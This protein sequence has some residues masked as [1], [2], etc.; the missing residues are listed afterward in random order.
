M[1][2]EVI[3]DP[4]GFMDGIQVGDS[5]KDLIPQTEMKKFHAFIRKVG[6]KGFDFAPQINIT[7]DNTSYS[8]SLMGMLQED[9]VYAS[10][11]QVPSYLTFIYEDLMKIINELGRQLRNSQRKSATKTEFN[12]D[13][14]KILNDYSQLNNELVSMQR[15]LAI[16][17]HELTKAYKNI[18]KLSLTDPLTGAGNRRHFMETIAGEIDRS[19]RYGHPLSLIMLDIDFFKKVN[20]TYGHSAGDKVL[21]NFTACCETTLRNSDCFFR[22]GGEEFAI[23][24]INADI[25]SA[26]I[27][28]ERIRKMIAEIEIEFENKIIQITTS[29][30][31]AELNKNENI[32]TFMKRADLALYKAK[33]SGRNRVICATATPSQNKACNFDITTT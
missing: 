1:L 20:D 31:V 28:A 30:G 11:I 24:L 16:K 7:R 33:N 17:N 13:T 29:S 6:A 2:I 26:K 27:S 5:F 14:Q 21:Q 25:E 10:A 15:E 9:A 19:V 23:L 22:I 12:H 8:L 4:E 18:E 3:N 32:D